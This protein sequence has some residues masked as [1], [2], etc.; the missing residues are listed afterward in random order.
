MKAMA[1]YGIYVVDTSGPREKTLDLITESDLSY[2]SFGYPA[3]MEA[4]VKSA[5]GG[6]SHMIAGV[7]IP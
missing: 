7:P 4:F 6:T 2:T 1:H 5:G 3:E